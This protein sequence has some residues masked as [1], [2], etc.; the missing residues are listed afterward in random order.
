MVR[1]LSPAIAA[2]SS[3]RFPDV[4]EAIIQGDDEGDA[5]A[6][7]EEALGL[8]L[9]TYPEHGL[10]LPRPQM[11]DG[12]LAS[13]LVA[14]DV[15]AKPAVLEAFQEAKSQNLDSAGASIMTR[16][17]CVGFLTRSIRPDCQRSQ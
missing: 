12:D 10:P 3:Y 6:M 8:A 4:P 1:N 5:R 17:R 11:H 2:G 14:P 15:A 9:L 16:K 7:A 13:V